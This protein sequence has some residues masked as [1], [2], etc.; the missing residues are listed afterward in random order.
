MEDGQGIAR[1]VQP[2]SR[3]VAR[4]RGPSLLKRKSGC[5]DEQ[6]DFVSSLLECA[7]LSSLHETALSLL[8]SMSAWVCGGLHPTAPEVSRLAHYSERSFSSREIT[9]SRLLG[10]RLPWSVLWRP[11]LRE[12]V[13]DQLRARGQ[14]ASRPDSQPNYPPRLESRI[15]TRR[16]HFLFGCAC[17][18]AGL[19]CPSRIVK[20]LRYCTLEYIRL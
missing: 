16:V 9:S 4:R 8:E 13:D 14:V 18:C 5:R 3:R 10:I 2:I 17:L 12:G 7:S 20:C 11:E 15:K 19:S 1:W 6:G